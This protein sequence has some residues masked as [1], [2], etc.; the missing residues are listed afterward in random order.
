[1][2]AHETTQKKAATVPQQPDAPPPPLPRFARTATGLLL[3][4]AFGLIVALDAA[5]KQGYVYAAVGVAVVATGLSEYEQ[6]LRRL[7]V[8]TARAALVYGGVALFL[9]QWA[10]WVSPAFPDPWLSAVVLVALLAMG[11]LSERVLRAQVEGSLESVAGH[12]LGLVYVPMLLGFLTA[13]RAQWGV[14]GLIVVAA[15][16]KSGSSGAYFIGKNFGRIRITP[17]VSPRK[18]LE[19]ALGAFAAAMFVS[20]ALSHSPWAVMGPRAALLYGALLAGAGIMGDLTE[21]LLKRQAGVKDSGRV[22]PG[23]GGM[24]DIVD[25][26]LF[27]APVSFAFLRLYDLYCSGG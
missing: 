11:L 17:V 25:D 12:T 26:L 21:S 27:A 6:L 18:T 2:G 5:W 13:V 23:L 8:Q 15:V 24:L 20:W 4:A 22:L 10:G 9:L 1:M 19:G 14:A 3:L 7:G 16:S